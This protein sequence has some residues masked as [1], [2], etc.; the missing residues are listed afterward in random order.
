M[1]F[2]AKNIKRSVAHPVQNLKELTIFLIL[3][4]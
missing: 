4:T 1:L 3:K 2:G